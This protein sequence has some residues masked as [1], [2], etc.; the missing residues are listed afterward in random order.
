MDKLGA[1]KKCPK[2]GCNVLTTT[3]IEP[4]TSKMLGAYSDKVLCNEYMKIKCERCGYTKKEA[5]LD[6]EEEKQD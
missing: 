2:C 6:R 1:M 4:I 5:P 3:Y